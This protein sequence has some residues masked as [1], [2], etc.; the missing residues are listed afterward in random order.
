MSTSMYQEMVVSFF[1]WKESYIYKRTQNRMG[2]GKHAEGIQAT[3]SKQ[4][5]K[6]NGDFKQFQPI[7]EIQNT[8][9]PQQVHWPN[10]Q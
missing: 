10:K 5:G 8:H 1:N 3:P 2:Y 9:A 6:K 7:N 4:D